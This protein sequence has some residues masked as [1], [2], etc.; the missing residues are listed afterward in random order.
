MQAAQSPSVLYTWSGTGDIRQWFKGFGTNTITL[1]NTT[2]GELTVSE[3]GAAGSTVAI[4]DDFNRI[5]ETPTG[6]GGGLDLTGLDFLEFD[7]AHSGAGPIN[8]QFYTQATPSST[9][10]A[11]GGDVAVAGGGV[12]NTYQVPLSGLTAAQLVYLRTIGL[13]VRD[14]AGLGN[15]TWT[16]QE[17][18]SGGTPLDVRDLITHDAGTP[19]GGLQ[20]RS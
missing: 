13:N 12:V 19:E 1:A 17:I 20:V 5:R 11:F 3:T 8:V 2:A 16:L 4:S 18:R 14:H 9:F 15:V 6:S 10:V 7:V